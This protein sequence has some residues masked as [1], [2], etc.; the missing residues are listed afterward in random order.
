M[1]IGLLEI[2]GVSLII[3]VLILYLFIK[4]EKSNH[5]KII[6]IRKQAS[7][8][9]RFYRLTLAQLFHI[10]V[11]NSMMP[12][13][14]KNSEFGEKYKERNIRIHKEMGK[15]LNKLE[16]ELKESLNQIDTL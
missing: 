6:F 3:G 2:L 15:K 5:R 12:E 7:L 16:I 9:G 1:N 14:L 4:Q 8:M 11:T 13:V 10:E